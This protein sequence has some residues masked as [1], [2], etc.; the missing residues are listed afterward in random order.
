MAQDLSIEYPNYAVL[1]TVRTIASR[2]WFV[3][4]AKLTQNILAF[5]AKYQ[6]RY[7]FTL[8]AFALVGNHYHL[9]AR[10]PKLNRAAFLSAFNGIIPKLLSS[11]V[12]NFIDGK[13]WARRARVQVVPNPEDIQDR[14]LYVALNHVS[15]GL[16]KNA[17]DNNGYTCIN[18]SLRTKPRKL[19]LI[20]WTDFMNRFRY[21]S[22][23]TPEDCK[24]EYTLTFSRLPGF[25]D[26]SDQEYRSKIT[27]LIE[28]R[29]LQIIAERTQN[30]L[31]FAGREN[32]K[33]T[34]PG[35]LPRFT[36][37]STRHS[38]R[39]LVLTRCKRTRR[40]FLKLY[41]HTLELY[42]KASSLYRTGKTSTVF[43]PN[44]YRPV[45]FNGT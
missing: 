26:L 6:E 34:A 21:N 41:F 25:E 24:K 1:I 7:G 32:L 20:D 11:L 35:S 29:R 23:L 39:P 19:F 40:M 15:S 37:T 2:L 42:R 44:T 8:Y 45:L 31:G 12:P 14:F 13:L 10:F 22:K 38:K 17:S 27:S 28:E 4:N 3:N 33:R 16:C 18:D 9:L 36:K 43:P 30:G 5:L